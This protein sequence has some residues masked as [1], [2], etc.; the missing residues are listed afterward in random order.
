MKDNCQE[1]RTCHQLGCQNWTAKVIQFF[2]Q[3]WSERRNDLLPL[4]HVEVDRLEEGLLYDVTGG[5]ALHAQSV[6]RILV[7]QLK[8]ANLEGFLIG[9]IL[10]SFIT[11]L[12]ARLISNNLD[13]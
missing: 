10:G 12:F 5:A 9:H 7:K 3:L 1:H 4:D 13:H 11:K 8:K 2:Y 6:V